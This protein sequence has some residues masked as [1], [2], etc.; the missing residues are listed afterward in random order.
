M[1]RVTLWASDFV[2]N[3]RITGAAVVD[4]LDAFV[5]TDEGLEL[6]AAGVAELA[7]FRRS[8]IT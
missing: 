3:G 7:A 8:W 6:E 1:G 4:S 2:G 5:A